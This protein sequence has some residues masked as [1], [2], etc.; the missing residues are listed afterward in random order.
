MTVSTTLR[1]PAT[2]LG[3]VGSGII[4]AGEFRRLATWSQVNGQAWASAVATWVTWPYILTIALGVALLAVAWLLAR[5]RAGAPPLNAVLLAVLWVTPLLLLPPMLSTDAGSYADLGWMVMNGDNPYTT[6]LGT[7]GGP[8]AY[9]RAWRGTTSIYPA[10]SLQLFGWIVQATGAHWYWSVVALRLLAVAG[11]AALLWAVPRLARHAG[12]D[13]GFAVWVAALNPLTLVH[14]VGGEHVDLLMAGLIAVALAAA[15]AWDTPALGTEHRGGW[16]ASP[17]LWV[18]AVV[19]GLAAA[20]K[21][22]ALLAVPA[23]AALAVPAGRRTWPKVLAA[24]VVVGLGSLATFWAVSVGSGLGFGWLGGT[25]NPANG[26][27][28]PTVAYLVS[29]FV[30]GDVD[31][32]TTWGQYLAVGIVA[33]LFVWYGRREPLRF[34]GLAALAWVLGFGVLR[35]WYLVF[36]LAF[37]GLSRPGR[38][39]RATVHLLAPALTLYGVWHE[40]G[41]AAVLTDLTRAFAWTAGMLVFAGTIWLLTRPDAAARGSAT[42]PVASV[43]P[44][45]VPSVAAS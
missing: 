29:R 12:V 7:T 22:P 2:W 43:P 24:N 25:G 18:G 11:L 4:A 14:G 28:T 40:Y 3:L 10:G 20:V 30:G 13:P 45:R 36:P 32:L 6:G 21:Q 27:Q 44:E 35:E 42:A 19:L 26:A 41:R 23:V 5:P 38:P 37:L 1:H 34:L 17:G 8:F 16:L 33:W 39:L 31:T 9:G 15:V